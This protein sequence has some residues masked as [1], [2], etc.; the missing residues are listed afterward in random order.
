MPKGLCYLSEERLE[1]NL[2]KIHE[3]VF[4]E[5]EKFPPAKFNAAKIFAAKI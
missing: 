4:S 1:L 5:G 3:K 2:T